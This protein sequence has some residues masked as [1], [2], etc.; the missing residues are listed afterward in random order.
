MVENPNTWRLNN[1]LLKNT[2]IEKKVS[3][4]IFFNFN[5]K[6]SK[7]IISKFGDVAKTMLRKKSKINLRQAE[8]IKIRAEINETENSKTEK[9]QQNLN[10]IILS[11]KLINFWPGQQVRRNKTK[12]L[13]SQMEQEPSGLIPWALKGY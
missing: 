6:G 13:T 8:E 7:N 11:I 9:N 12:Q 4:E 5:L 10:L 1:T 2:L 3:R